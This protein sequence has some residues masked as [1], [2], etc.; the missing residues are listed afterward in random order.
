M[1]STRARLR[2]PGPLH[3]AP[4]VVRHLLTHP[5]D[6]AVVLSAAWYLR[7]R[8]WWR[9]APFLPLPGPQYWHFRITTL[10]GST[11]VKPNAAEIVAAARWA[12]AQRVAR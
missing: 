11:E 4:V 8:G 1:S 7:R 10:N 2:A 12:K 6:S 9:H 3:V 5:G